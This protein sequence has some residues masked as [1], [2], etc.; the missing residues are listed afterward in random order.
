MGQTRL[1]RARKI[2]KVL[3]LI[4]VMQ[5]AEANGKLLEP[6]YTTLPIAQAYAIEHAPASG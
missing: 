4:E 6:D 2:H 3:R 5:D 1:D